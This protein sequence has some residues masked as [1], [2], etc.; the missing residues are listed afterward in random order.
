MRKSMIDKYSYNGCKNS[1][2]CVLVPE[3]NLCA[4]NCD[5]PLPSTMS[6]SFVSNLTQTAQSSCATCPTPAPV[7]CEQMVA[8]CVNG[9]CVAANPS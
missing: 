1:S 3:N 8:A 2:D 6:S 5:I 4:W 7:L 9:K